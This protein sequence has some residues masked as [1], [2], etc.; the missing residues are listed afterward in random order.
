MKI[1]ETF[2]NDDYIY[3]SSTDIKI[4]NKAFLDTVSTGTFI[5]KWLFSA[6]VSELSNFTANFKTVA[7]VT[8]LFQLERNDLTYWWNGSIWEL[9][10]E[11]DIAKSNTKQDIIDHIST[12]I[13]EESNFKVI[14]VIDQQ[15]ATESFEV[16]NFS[17][18]TNAGIN[19]IDGIR[20]NLF[21][22]KV[23]VYND[24]MI[25]NDI[26]QGDGL[27]EDELV[28]YIDFTASP[29]PNSVLELAKYQTYIKIFEAIYYEQIKNLESVTD[30]TYWQN[31]YN[32]LMEKI[33]SGHVISN[34][35]PS[36]VSTEDNADSPHF[37][38]GEYGQPLGDDELDEFTVGKF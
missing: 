15:N 13:T 6:T 26:K 22:V 37:G 11:G 18:I 12:F 4:E 1:T 27:V 35:T 28:N 2:R 3:V 21:D 30:I 33:K 29:L 32:I 19:T 17:F 14:I 31:K 8:Y 38:M 34:Q 36:G 10:D 16:Y 23:T 7:S 20:K 24:Y 9:A 5:I 25:N